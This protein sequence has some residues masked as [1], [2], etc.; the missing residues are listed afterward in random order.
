MGEGDLRPNSPGPIPLTFF[1]FIHF[2]SVE[3]FMA[4]VLLLKTAL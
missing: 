2:S 4:F 3:V 1:R